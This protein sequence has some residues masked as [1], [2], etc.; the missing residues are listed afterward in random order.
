MIC[1]FLIKTKTPVLFR[2]G[3]PSHN[4]HQRPGSLPN[5][6]TPMVIAI[7]VIVVEVVL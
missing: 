6:N 4:G 5:T 7:E 3:C 2:R 1:T